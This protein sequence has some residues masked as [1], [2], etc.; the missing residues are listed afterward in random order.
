M[1]NLLLL[2]CLM[3]SGCAT[4]FKEPEWHFDCDWARFYD[5][6]NAARARLDRMPYD[7]GWTKMFCDVDPS[8]LEYWSAKRE[9]PHVRP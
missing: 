1:K 6:Q 3:L 9:V 4:L 2:A 8:S 7:N 5:F